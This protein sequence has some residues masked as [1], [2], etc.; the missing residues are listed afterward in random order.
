MTR[1][2]EKAQRLEVYEDME[3]ESRL[4]EAESEYIEKA[5]AE[6]AEEAEREVR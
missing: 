6:K 2:E 1:L 5:D 3:A 4:K